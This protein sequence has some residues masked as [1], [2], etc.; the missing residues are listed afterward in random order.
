M[1]PGIHPSNVKIKLRKKLAMRPVNST[2]R[3]GKI[4]QKKYRSAF[5]THPSAFFEFSSSSLCDFPIRLS[6]IRSLQSPDLTAGRDKA[7][8]VAIQARRF[9]LRSRSPCIFQCARSALQA[10][11]DDA[12]R[13]GPHF[14]ADPAQRLLA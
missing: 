8:A 9:A 3:G 4:T 13:R 5:M 14:P 11:Q 6:I 12:L 2:A 10:F 1:T 7:G